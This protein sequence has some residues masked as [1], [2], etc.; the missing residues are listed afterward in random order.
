[1]ADL[2]RALGLLGL[3]LAGD[4]P[5]ML[6]V[7]IDG[8]G[9]TL[10]AAGLA[11]TTPE[12]VVLRIPTRRRKEHRTPADHARKY[13][14]RSCPDGVV[15]EQLPFQSRLPRGR[16]SEAVRLRG[17][18]PEHLDGAGDQSDVGR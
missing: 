18:R 13:D 4:R 15:E 11:E 2:Q 8:L 6:A 9:R 7:A 17:V 12:A 1:M 5:V 10:H 3:P 16:A 14:V